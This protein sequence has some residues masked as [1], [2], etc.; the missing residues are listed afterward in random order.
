LRRDGTGGDGRRGDVRED[1]FGV[2]GSNII[3][4]DSAGDLIRALRESGR[5]QRG[6]RPLFEIEA[7]AATS[8]YWAQRLRWL[9]RRRRA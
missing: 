8:R 9:R 3:G 4:F 2:S 6:E 5:K 1:R 7:R